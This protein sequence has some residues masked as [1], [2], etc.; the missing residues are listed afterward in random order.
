MTVRAVILAR[1]LGTR[2]RQSQPGAAVDSAQSVVAATGV[3]ALIPIGRPFLDYVLSAL[4]D[5]GVDRI[6]LVI[7]PEH[8]VV[9]DHYARASLSRVSVEFAIQPEP[10][11]TADAVM[12]AEPWAGAEPFLVLNSDNYY[13]VPIL[14][15]LAALDQPG[16]AA[17]SREGL[18]ADGLIEPERIAR[19]ALLELGGLHL[20]RIVE[21][22]DDESARALGRDVWVSMNCWRFDAR[23]FDVCRR[24]ARSARGEF[25]LPVAVQLA[26][27]ERLFPVVAVQT[28]LPV[29]DL[30]SRSDIA[31]VATRLAGV[32]VRL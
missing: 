14:Q 22:P 26:L 24:V 25:E 2:M 4:A 31:G 32:E 7:G 10:L 17:F 30:S 6:C 16:V 12:A 18:L 23:V 8:D 1:G 29:L 19:F 11:G 28:H 3:K 5:A 27:D 13:P 20:R 9:R 21:K 15:A